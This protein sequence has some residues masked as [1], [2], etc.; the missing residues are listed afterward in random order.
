MK[1]LKFGGTSVGSADNIRRIGE[2][3]SSQQESI[4]VVVS[5]LGGITDQLLSV[6]K[7]AANGIDPIGELS[8]IWNR[9]ES[10]INNLLTAEK[11]SCLSAV[12][13]LYEELEKIVQGVRLTGELTPKTLDKILGFGER[14][15]SIV[16]SHF[17][18]APLLDSSKV[19][20][21]DRHHG[22]ANVD[23]PITY[24]LIK[25]SWSSKDK[26]TVAPGFISSAGDGSMQVPRGCRK[27]PRPC[28]RAQRLS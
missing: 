12:K 22:K 4:I 19:I 26:V 2:I 11:E 18:K 15:S 21:T 9:H 7:R 3:V 8:L 23:F 10:T 27:S 25:Q 14:M 16:I 13:L 1:I 28:A 20:R 24:E 5:A 17:L 6:A